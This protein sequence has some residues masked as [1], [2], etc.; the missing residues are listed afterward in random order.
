MTS[1][2]PVVRSTSAWPPLT[3][4]AKIS[5]K[6]TR[7]LDVSL[8]CRTYLPG[9]RLTDQVPSHWSESSN[10]T[11]TVGMAKPSLGTSLISRSLIHSGLI[12]PPRY[13]IEPDAVT[14]PALSFKSRSEGVSR[15]V[16]F[17]VTG[18]NP[19]LDAE[20]STVVFEGTNVSYWPLSLV[21]ISIDS[22]P[23]VTCTV[24]L[25]TPSATSALLS[26][27]KSQNTLP[28]SLISLSA[29]RVTSANSPGI[30]F[31]MFLSPTRIRTPSDSSS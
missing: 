22:S 17:S 9:S 8:T 21:C 27:S 31:P 18:V 4:S 13:E 15:I 10:S 3:R 11:V 12:C 24:A 30:I 28:E 2:P 23:N 14:V 26:L 19:S 7:F 20:T 29:I 5:L 25:D 16:R 1:H 6:A